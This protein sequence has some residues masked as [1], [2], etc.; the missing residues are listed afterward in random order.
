MKGVETL[1]GLLIKYCDAIQYLM[2]TKENVCNNFYNTFTITQI[3]IMTQ[4]L[5]TGT[6]KIH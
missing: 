1:N 3:T 6:F 5:I 2:N 4:Y